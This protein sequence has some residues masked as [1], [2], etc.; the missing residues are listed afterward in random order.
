[1]PAPQDRI[2]FQD[3]LLAAIFAA[4]TAA[5]LVIIR[6][7]FNTGIT[8]LVFFGLGLVWAV[9]VLL[10]K[11][12]ARAQAAMTTVSLPGGVP[13]RPSKARLALLGG[14]L[15]VLGATLAAFA[16]PVLM[17]G[18]G[19]FLVAVGGALLAGIA[20][21]RLP[22]GHLQFDTEGITFAQRQ[23]EARVPWDAITGLARHDISDN[24][25]VLIA[26]DPDAVVAKPAHFRPR[27]LKGMA[28][29]H[30]MLGADFLIMTGAYG[31]DA[32]LLMAALKRYATE[33][34]ARLEL[35]HRPQ[36]P[37]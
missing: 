13:I 6:K 4:F 30:G 21:G 37:R 29:S 17:Q 18:I 35:Q 25:C 22:G 32:P 2:T 26:V 14:G 11:R 19:W 7:D 33:P 15:L 8:T 31:M 23:G 5:S 16:A 28:Q 3:W 36:L 10:R 12:R 20:A 1:M 9:S 24:P 27:L 34:A